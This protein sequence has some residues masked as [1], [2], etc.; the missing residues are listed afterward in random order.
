MG[1]KNIAGGVPHSQAAEGQ[2]AAA[3]DVTPVVGD[4]DGDL[5]LQGAEEPTKSVVGVNNVWLELP[6]EYL[7]RPEIVEVAEGTVAI[8]G[9]REYGVPR[10]TQS[11]HLFEDE[12]GDGGMIA[13]DD[14]KY[15]HTIPRLPSLK[16][17][18][19]SVIKGTIQY[20]IL[21]KR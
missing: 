9:V 17:A 20:Q 14:D 21:M 18:Q 8:H 15:F 16:N 6:D 7:E 2:Y 12:G 13:A 11:V 19:P 3:V 4:H 1:D 5:V 10:L